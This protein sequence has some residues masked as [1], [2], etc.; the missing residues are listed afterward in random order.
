MKK[1]LAKSIVVHGV[2]VVAAVYLFTMPPKQPEPKP[3]EIVA[4]TPPSKPIAIVPPPPPPKCSAPQPTN[5]PP[6]PTP[7]VIAANTP[8]PTPA[9]VPLPEPVVEQKVE[10]KPEVKPEPVVAQKTEPK[11]EPKAE[12]K[13]TPPPPP[14]FTPAQAANAKDA[15]LGYLFGLINE[16]KEYPKK[17]ERLGQSGIV[18]VKMTIEPDGSVTDISLVG[19]C[20]FSL[21]DKAAVTLIESLKKIKELP[22]EMAQK[23]LTITVPIEYKQ[24]R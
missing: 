10:P 2:L 7:Q 23:S 20:E 18:K 4:I 12:V 15:Y 6:P 16:K 22:K 13:P 9:S 8:E 17:A 19:S 24:S 14:E 5:T 21:L 3:I 1:H 11:V